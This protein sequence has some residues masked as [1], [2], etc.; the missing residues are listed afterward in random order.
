M[1]NLNA[2]SIN[3]GRLNFTEDTMYHRGRIVKMLDEDVCGN[4]VNVN[5]T[6]YKVSSASDDLMMIMIE[7][8][9]KLSDN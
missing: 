9:F 8:E 5:P 3:V 1:S 7:D 4:V 2:K 6:I